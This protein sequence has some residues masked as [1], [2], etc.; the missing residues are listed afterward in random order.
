MKR[1]P[2]LGAG[3]AAFLTGCGGNHLVRALPGV[4]ALKGQ[5]RPN[6]ANA[7]LVP[8]VADAIPED[9][10]ARP[11][12]GEAARFDGAAAPL[13]WLLCK[14]KRCPSP[15]TSTYSRSSARWPAATARPPS[16]SPTRAR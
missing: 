12:V 16:R 8:A 15:R 7:R 10:I 2:F 14:G 3:A 11:I 1:A 13:G 5:S 9:V 6:L 4:A